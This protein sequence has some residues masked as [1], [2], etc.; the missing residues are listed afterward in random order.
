[1]KELYDQ[2]GRGYTSRRQQE[3]RIFAHI[4]QQLDGA[5][6]VLNVGA[7]VGAY[8]PT[9]LPVVAVEPS[10]QMISQRRQCSNIVQAKAEALP[11][12]DSAFDSTMAVLT[13]HHWQDKK[14]GLTECARTARKQIVIFT[15]DPE[16]NGFWLV[17]DYFPE[18]LSF[19][20]AIFPTVAEIERQLGRITVQ[21]VPIPADCVDGFLGAYWCRPQAYLDRGIRSGM[22]SFS[23]IPDVETRIDELSKDLAS[24]GWERKHRHL[25]NVDALDVGYRLITV[26]LQ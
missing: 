9:D 2:I 1:M 15:W 20:R 24:G 25:L 5:S 18:L 7:G 4:R 17:Q 19:D 8:E 22:S 12:V 6:A 13:L 21:P 14:K 10:A 23:R 26:R 16:S 3:P 11:F